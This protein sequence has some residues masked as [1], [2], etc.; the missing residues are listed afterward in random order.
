MGEKKQSITQQHNQKWLG[1]EYTSSKMDLY[2]SCSLSMNSFIVVGW[3]P[4]WVMVKGMAFIWNQACV[5]ILVPLLISFSTVDKLILLFR[6]QFPHLS[7]QLERLREMIYYKVPTIG[8]AHSYLS[9]NGSYF[10]FVS[11]RTFLKA[12]WWGGLFLVLPGTSYREYQA[13]SLVIQ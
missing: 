3:E 7:N 4:I 5:Q 12:L 2:N 8:L 10:W 13:L 9:I 1:E 6:P 11:I